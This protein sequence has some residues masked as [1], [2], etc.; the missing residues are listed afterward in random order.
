MFSTS[1]TFDATTLTDA[2]SVLVAFQYSI[3]RLP[4]HDRLGSGTITEQAGQGQN[5]M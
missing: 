4:V 2:C 1:R 5:L 3:L